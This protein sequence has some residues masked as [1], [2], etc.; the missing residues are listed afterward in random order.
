MKYGVLGQNLGLGIKK[1]GLF[2]EIS[3]NSVEQF[4]R[5][6]F[7]KVCITIAMFKLALPINLLIM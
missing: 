1:Q 7:L 6:R 4:C 3:K 5:I 2:Y